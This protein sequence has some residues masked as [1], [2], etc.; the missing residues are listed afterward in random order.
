[1]MLANH[2]IV[3]V[4]DYGTS[5]LNIYSVSDTTVC[6]KMNQNAQEKKQTD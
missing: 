1:M 4:M 5:A 6:K 3:Y 2:I